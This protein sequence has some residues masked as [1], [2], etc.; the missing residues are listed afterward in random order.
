MTDLAALE[1]SAYVFDS[2][3]GKSFH[4]LMAVESHVRSKDNFRAIQ[5]PM[6]RD[7]LREFRDPLR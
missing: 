1:I 7:Q 2:D 3:S 5:E 6:M 4:S